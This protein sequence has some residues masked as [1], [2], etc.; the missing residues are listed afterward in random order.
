[1]NC[2]HEFKYLIII[3]PFTCIQRLYSSFS[4]LIKFLF[5]NYSQVIMKLKWTIAGR[6]VDYYSRRVDYYRS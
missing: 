5:V 6:R 3:M 2:N 1:M 4:Y